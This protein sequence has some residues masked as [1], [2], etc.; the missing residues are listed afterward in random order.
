MPTSLWSLDIHGYIQ[1][2]RVAIASLQI[3]ISIVY[4]NSSYFAIRNSVALAVMIYTPEIHS[5]YTITVILS[6]LPRSNDFST[7]NDATFS[8]LSFPCSST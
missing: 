3:F 8:R 5:Q 1:V 7:R 6:V 4:S 2:R